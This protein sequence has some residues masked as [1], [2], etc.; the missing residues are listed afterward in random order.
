MRE[1][2]PCPGADKNLRRCEGCKTFHLCC[3]E[4]GIHYCYECT[5][6]PCKRFRA[7]AKRWQKYGQNFIENQLLLKEIGTEQFLNLKNSNLKN[8]THEEKQETQRF[9]KIIEVENK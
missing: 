1:K 2:K 4:K 9:V 8:A 3:M 5:D 7:F 6:F